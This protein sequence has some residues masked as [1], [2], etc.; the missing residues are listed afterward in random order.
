MKSPDSL[1]LSGMTHPPRSKPPLRSSSG[2]P[3]PC[4]TPSTETLVMVVSFTIVV[5]FSTTPSSSVVALIRG[6][7]RGRLHPSYERLCPDPTPPP[8]LFEDF[9]YAG[10]QRS[11][12]RRLEATALHFL[13][14]ASSADE[15]WDQIDRED[16]DW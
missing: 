9:W 10:C 4:I 15:L 3:S 14:C 16:P 13:M 5:P 8:D 11:T 2:P 6:R 7:P 1:S 12:A